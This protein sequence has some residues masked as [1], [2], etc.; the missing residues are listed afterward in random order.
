MAVVSEL[1]PVT[2]GGTVA[3]GVEFESD[4]NGKAVTFAS[5]RACGLILEAGVLNDIVMAIVY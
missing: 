4:A 3:A 5:G 1:T 2:L